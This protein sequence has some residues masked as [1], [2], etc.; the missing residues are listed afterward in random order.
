MKDAPTCACSDPFA[1]DRAASGAVVQRFG[2]E[3]LLLLL[4]WRDVRAAARDH[5]QFD[6]GQCGRV[7]TPPEDGIRDFRQLPIEANPPE[8]GA[9]KDIVQPFFRRPTKPDAKPLFEAVVRRHLTHAMGGE[10]IEVVRDV[11]LPLQSDALVVLLDT[12]P[13]LAEEWVGWGLHALRTDGVT[14]PQKAKRFLTFID[15]MLDRGKQEADMGL[16]STLHT[17][18]FQGRALNRDEMRGICHLA[19]AG[20]RDTVIN[21]VTGTLAYFAE[22][23][24]EL[25][26]LRQSPDLIPVAVEELFRVLSPLGM[27][28]RVCP[29]GH[30]LG[31]HHVAADARVGLCWAA[32]NR[33]PE[34]FQAP[35]EVRLDRKPNPHVAFGA[36]THTCLG[37][38]MARLVLRTAL[39]F[40]AEKVETI[41]VLASQPRRSPFGTPYLFDSLVLRLN[42]RGDTS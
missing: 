3:D 21:A 1:A 32:A 27:I 37:A 34:V 26:R 23:P 39:S 19:L 7:P 16:F 4:R 40:L 38:P 9:W 30:T 13:A 31:G 10:P 42:P 11:A 5:A 22:T 36:G 6:S 12:D 24:I 8:H 25:E 17:A 2:K 20:G 29:N 41:D 35:Q 33:D 14:D 18:E 28:G 15:R